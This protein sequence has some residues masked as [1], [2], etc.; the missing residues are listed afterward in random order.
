MAL[1]QQFKTQLMVPAA[2]PGKDLAEIDFFLAETM[3]LRPL[4]LLVLQIVI[5]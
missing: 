5:H 4:K 3:V 2:C 1:A